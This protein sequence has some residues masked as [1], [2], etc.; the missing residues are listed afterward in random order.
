MLYS[1]IYTSRAVRPLD[2][3]SLQTLLAQARHHNASQ[4]LTGV[5]LYAGGRFLQVLEGPRTEVEA[6]FARI[7][8]D[9]R[10]VHVRL[11]GRGVVRRREFPQ[12]GMGFRR[13]SY[14]VWAQLRRLLGPLQAVVDLPRV[15]T[16]VLSLGEVIRPFVLYPM[17][18]A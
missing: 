12:W 3:Q 8:R 10:H 16:R 13:L 6:L 5:L 17:A 14:P 9:P 7:Q 2:E 4:H 18:L 15:P 1:L 11:V